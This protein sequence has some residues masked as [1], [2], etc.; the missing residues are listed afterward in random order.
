MSSE[1][2]LYYIDADGDTFG[3]IGTSVRSCFQP[4]GMVLDSTDCD[5]SNRFSNPEAAEVCDGIDNNCNFLVDDDDEEFIDLTTALEYF[6]DIDEDGY[7][8]E[9]VVGVKS[10]EQPFGYIGRAGDCDDLNPMVYP[11]A[12][13][14]CDGVDNNCDGM[15]DGADALDVSKWYLD[16]DGDAY[17]VQTFL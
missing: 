12:L 2:D 10:C 17:G 15:S 13:E 6:P 9:N 8:D 4:A 7:G 3:W 16:A 5:D 11:V 14:I 1:G